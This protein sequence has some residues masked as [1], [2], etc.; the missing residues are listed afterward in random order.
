MSKSVQFTEELPG[1][2]PKCDLTLPSTHLSSVF[3]VHKW[4]GDKQRNIGSTS[5]HVVASLTHNTATQR[6][7]KRV[8]LQWLCW[9]LV[10][11]MLPSLPLLGLSGRSMDQR[12]R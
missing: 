6:R 5:V 11:R 12:E 10:V 1:S 4:H 2:A 7:A 8:R 3:N 9:A